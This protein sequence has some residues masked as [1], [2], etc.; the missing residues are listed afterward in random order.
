MPTQTV[1][2]Q[3]VRFSDSHVLLWIYILRLIITQGL[4]MS[5]GH[6]LLEQFLQSNFLIKCYPVG[7]SFH[8]YIYSNNGF[9]S[10]IINST[11]CLRQMNKFW[12]QIQQI[13]VA[14]EI[15]SSMFIQK[16]TIHQKTYHNSKKTINLLILNLTFWPIF[17]SHKRKWVKCHSYKAYQSVLMWY[18]WQLM[19]VMRK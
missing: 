1:H 10:T 6:R 13:T 2:F 18:L 3:V 12:H 14:V 5:V 11:G 19:R 16:Q 15:S 4:L 9:N 7:H 17:I 8:M